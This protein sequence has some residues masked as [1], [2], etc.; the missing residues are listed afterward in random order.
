[1]LLLKDT[2]WRRDMKALEVRRLDSSHS[3]SCGRG[4]GQEE[5]RN[6]RMRILASIEDLPCRMGLVQA[7]ELLRKPNVPAPSE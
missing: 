1:M 3:R 5:R 7:A 4:I 6:H 2:S